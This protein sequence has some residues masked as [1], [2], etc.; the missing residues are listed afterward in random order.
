MYPTSRQPRTYH[1]AL[2]SQQAAQTRERVLDAAAVCFAANGYGR[3][4]LASIAERAGVSVETVQANGPKRALLMASFERV[5]TGDEGPRPVSETPTGQQILTEIDLAGFR[6]ALVAFLVAANSRG[7]RL[8]RAF[9]AA[10]DSD[11]EVMASLQ[12]LWE[13]RRIDVTAAI[14]ALIERGAVISDPAAAADVLSF[15]ISPEGYEQLVL[16]AGWSNDTYAHW[17]DQAIEQLR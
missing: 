1:S 14:A 17:L 16:R 6:A 11:K 9:E 7:V 4:T 12:Q 8:W 13:R 5:F 10:A 2:R 3:T 15:L